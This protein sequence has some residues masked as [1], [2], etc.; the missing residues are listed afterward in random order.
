MTSPPG[1]AER[2]PPEPAAPPRAATARRPGSRAAGLG[3]L[4]RT[5]VQL[6]PGQ[7]VHRARL[8]AQRGMLRRWPEAG[9]RLLTAPVPAGAR[10]WP[11][12]FRPVDARIS[13]SRPTAAQLRSGQLPLLGMARAL[14]D[15]PDWAQAGAPLLWRYHLHYWDW[16]WGLA[17]DPDRALARELFARLWRSW[18]Q[19]CGYRHPDAWHPYPAAVRA[20]SWCGLYGELVA[21]GAADL[22]FAAELAAH[23]G[24]LRRHV[25]SDV[26]GNHLIK[27]LKALAGLAVFFADGP[28]LRRSLRRLERQLAVQVLGDGG[29]YERSPAYHCQVLAD[30]IDVAGLVRSAGQTVPPA[31]DDAIAAMRGW[32]GVVLAPDGQVPLLNDGYPVAPDLMALLRPAA[33]SGSLRVLPE[34]GLVRAQVKGWRVLADV[35]A[36]CPPD[37]PAHAHADTFSCVVHVDGAPLLIDTGTS[38][39]DPGPVR[40]YERSTAAHNTVAVD[41]ADSTEVWGAFRAGRRARVAGVNARAESGRITIRAEHDGYRKLPARPVHQRSWLL[42]E[43]GLDV[44]DLVSGH[45]RHSVTVRW[46]L[47]PAAQVLVGQPRAPGG[48]DHTTPHEA[49]AIVSTSAGEFVVSVAASARPALTADSRPVAQRFGEA[50]P[51]PV[52]TCQVDDVL[53]IAVRT[54]WRARRQRPAPPPGVT[55]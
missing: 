20:W 42:T 9:R 38:T 2:L 12:A 48:A 55:S 22:P 51:A 35:G 11:G 30:L 33:A 16:A 17:A 6:R 3:P 21:G 53:P 39:Y 5:I 46:H 26:G 15:P 7:L 44:D 34:T 36:P 54:Q 50:A 10:G 4:A 27:D 29:H 52:L 1:A 37:L 31:L 23:A 19:E 49:C 40:D 47:P 18:R 24:F 8:G 41:G 32:L 14:G 45:G 28:L 43:A 13:P 25:E